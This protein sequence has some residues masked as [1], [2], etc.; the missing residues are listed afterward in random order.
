MSHENVSIKNPNIGWRGLN[1]NYISGSF[2]G[3]ISK[4]NKNFPSLNM[5][6]NSKL[7]VKHSIGKLWA[8]KSKGGGR[9]N[10]S[11]KGYFFTKQ[12]SLQKRN[13]MGFWIKNFKWPQILTNLLQK[14]KCVFNNYF[15]Y[16][17]TNLVPIPVELI[18]EHILCPWK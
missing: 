13:C 2:F 12:T 15:F 3:I 14:N 6:P 17:W 16:F 1:N 7:L 18:F 11:Q 5:H 10:W 8:S 4:N 9:G